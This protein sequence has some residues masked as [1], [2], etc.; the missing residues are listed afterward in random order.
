MSKKVKLTLAEIRALVDEE[1]L[2]EL[3]PNAIYAPPSQS[4]N[5]PKKKKVD[6][7]P[8]GEYRKLPGGTLQALDFEFKSVRAGIYVSKFLTDAQAWA[9]SWSAAITQPFTRLFFSQGFASLSKNA[10]LAKIKSEK[11]GLL[12]DFGTLDIIGTYNGQACV[13]YE[14]FRKIA[15]GSVGLLAHP[16]TKENIRDYNRMLNLLS[17]ETTAVDLALGKD[18]TNPAI[19][20]FKTDYLAGLINTTNQALGT[21]LRSGEVAS[22]ANSPLLCKNTSN[23]IFDCIELL[24]HISYENESSSYWIVYDYIVNPGSTFSPASVDVRIADGG[25]TSVFKR[26]Q[27]LY[28]QIINAERAWETFSATSQVQ[29]LAKFADMRQAWIKLKEPKDYI[30]AIIR[31]GLKYGLSIN[32]IG[33]DKSIA[34]VSQYVRESNELENKNLLSEVATSMGVGTAGFDVWLNEMTI[35]Q[36]DAALGKPSTGAGWG[37]AGDRAEL[38]IGS[39]VTAPPKETFTPGPGASWDKLATWYMEK[40]VMDPEYRSELNSDI[41]APT[42]PPGPGAVGPTPTPIGQLILPLPAVQGMY[43]VVKNITTGIEVYI[44]PFQVQAFTDALNGWLTNT[45]LESY[46]VLVGSPDAVVDPEVAE[47]EEEAKEKEGKCPEKKMSPSFNTSQSDRIKQIETTVN[48][49]L[50]HYELSQTI[51]TEDDN[52]DSAQ[53]DPAFLQLVKHASENVEDFISL[54]INASRWNDIGVDWKLY[55]KYLPPKGY[56]PNLTGML[57]FVTDAYNCELNYGKKRIRGGSGSGTKSRTGGV[58]AATDDIPAVGQEKGPTCDDGSPM[59]K[60]TWRD[61]EVNLTNTKRMDASTIKSIEAEIAKLSA[62][63]IAN[64][65]H[66]FNP[67][68]R[69]HTGVFNI[70]MR[71]RVK[72]RSSHD[73]NVPGSY[74]PIITKAI[75]R[76]IQDEQGWAKVRKSVLTITVP[77]GDYTGIVNEAKEFV[78]ILRRLIKEG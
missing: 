19:E 37:K 27:L 22:M 20:Q 6:P 51:G 68:T 46:D 55:A 28:A 54:N 12:A 56:T 53:N 26:L 44:N 75:K 39:N 63:W 16:Y 9:A 66:N 17:G 5:P 71:G 77:C 67:V 61:I 70:G 74:Q 59:E 73:W 30:E 15:K 36:T 8:D 62:Q 38:W 57:A 18:T 21:K 78:S 43:L 47:A 58:V 42:A 24:K 7:I 41:I 69:E 10:D 65:P 13:D 50:N 32:K 1:L 52:W 33:T 29:D 11:L 45:K 25:K 14:S 40:I 64:P 4:K 31:N 23:E 60:K 76:T 72:I 48:K 34:D 2:R 49:Y 35:E 3:K